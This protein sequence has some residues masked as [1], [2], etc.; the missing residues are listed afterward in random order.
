MHDVIIIGGGYAGMSC[1]ISLKSKGVNVLLMERNSLLGGI[2]NQN[3]QYGF[4]NGKNSFSGPIYAKSL[5]KQLNG[6]NI[7]NKLNTEVMEVTADNI[8]CV[9]ILNTDGVHVLNAKFVIFANGQRE[10]GRGAL[11]IAG[12]RPS[13]IFT[14]GCA[15]NLINVE[16][17]IIGKKI[18]LAM[19]NCSIVPQIKN[20]GYEFICVVEDSSLNY[21]TKENLSNIKAV[22]IRHKLISIEGKERLKSVII[23]KLDDKGFVIPDTEN[24]IYCDTLLITGLNLPEVELL[25]D[26]GININ[27]KTKGPTVDNNMQ[28][29]IKGVYACG[30][31]V[32]PHN[33]INS[34]LQEVDII[35]SDIVSKLIH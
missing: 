24:R 34:I 10:V 4:F 11:N 8:K 1:A 27:V 29:N 31:I 9:K 12:T 17:E 3:M 26:M 35:V 15:S 14:V 2:L 22:F 7:H 32:K 13:G 30:D 28:T 16:S 33:N 5:V 20:K 19:N 21:S 18:V 25:K 6:L 23:Q